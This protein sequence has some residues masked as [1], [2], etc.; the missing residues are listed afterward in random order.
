[1]RIYFVQEKRPDSKW[2]QVKTRSLKLTFTTKRAAKRGI[3][4]YLKRH[5]DAL[6]GNYRILSLNV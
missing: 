2:G 5:G 4:S 6:P 3:R 1:M